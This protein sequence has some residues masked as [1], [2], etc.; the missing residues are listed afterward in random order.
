MIKILE[1]TRKYAMHLNIIAII[2]CII[3]NIQV[4]FYFYLPVNLLNGWLLY[5][6]LKK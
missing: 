2:W 6:S 1:Y 5:V 4:N 3:V